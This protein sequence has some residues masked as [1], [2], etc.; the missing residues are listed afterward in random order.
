LAVAISGYFFI[1]LGNGDGTFQSATY[2]GAGGGSRDSV[3]VG[4][5]NRDGKPDLAVASIGVSV[6]LN[7][8]LTP[9]STSTRCKTRQTSLSLG[10]S[11]TPISSLNPRR[12]WFRQL[13]TSFRNNDDEQRSLRNQRAVGPDAKLFPLRKR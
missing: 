8:C 9:A 13:A 6:L 5:F 10:R 11:L 7:T 3:V 1:L 12:A 2:F 4:D